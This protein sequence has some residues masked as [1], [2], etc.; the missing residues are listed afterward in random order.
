[1]TDRIASRFFGVK[2]PDYLTLSATTWLPIGEPHSVTP[3]DVSRLRQ[4][5]RELQQNPQR[6][7]GPDLPDDAQLLVTEKINL[8]AQQHADAGLASSGQK[9]FRGQKRYRRFPEI[10]R[11]LA[12]RTVPQRKLILEELTQI[13]QSLAANKVL[14][15]RE[16]SFCLYPV[17]SIQ[18]MIS[19]LK[20]RL[21][22]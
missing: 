13:E 3:A 7:L 1:M 11:Q 8:I 18:T 10:N 4:M 14:T 6:Y 5:L 12:Q 2:L 9:A 16:F 15:S 21:A 22:R 17:E 19:G 20:D